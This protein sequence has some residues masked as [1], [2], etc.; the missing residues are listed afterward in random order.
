[1]AMVLRFLRAWA[2]VV[3]MCAVIFAFSQDGN[4]G[5]HSDELLG[6]LLSLFGANTPH[7][8]HLF[9]PYFRKLAHV[10]V[11]FFL[12]ALSYRGFGM[13]RSGFQFNAAARSLL[14]TVAYAATDEYH[15]SFVAT[16][17]PS[18]RD[19]GI[20]TC[21]GGFVSPEDP[22][23]G[24]ARDRIAVE[25]CPLRLP[26]SYPPFLRWERCWLYPMLAAW[27]STTPTRTR[28]RR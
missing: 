5:R 15:Q 22:D 24:A 19:V 6:W 11:Y 20:D 21:G 1:L 25:S 12:A 23:W 26:A 7:L 14:F 3:A 10:T 8:R 16:R 9:N 13:G 18:V 28:W 4:S 17:G 2:P 27:C